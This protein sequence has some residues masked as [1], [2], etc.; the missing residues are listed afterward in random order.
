MNTTFTW[1][2]NIHGQRVEER[3]EHNRLIT[4]KLEGTHYRAMKD[5]LEE[6]KQIENEGR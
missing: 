4:G 5:L 2:I 6:L 3:A 1:T